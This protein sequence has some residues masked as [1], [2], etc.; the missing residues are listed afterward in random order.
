MSNI[1]E[2]KK[3]NEI[4][5]E[6]R[7][8]LVNLIKNLSMKISGLRSLTEAIVTSGGVDTKEIDPSTMKSKLI[9]PLQVKLL[10]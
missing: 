3:V 8:T 10:M 1:S 5:K 4:T 9:Y 7:K 6:E 2:N